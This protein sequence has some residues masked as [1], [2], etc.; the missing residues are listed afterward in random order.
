MSFE[1]GE[2]RFQAGGQA[3]VG[4]RSVFS[5]DEAARKQ[6]MMAAGSS[7]LRTIGMGDFCVSTSLRGEPAP[8]GDLG[9]RC[10]ETSLDNRMFEWRLL[11]V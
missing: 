4:A 8:N 2:A 11:C 6:P 9:C 5:R 7:Q 10:V 3:G 1:E